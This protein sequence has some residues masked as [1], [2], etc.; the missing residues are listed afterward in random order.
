MEVLSEAALHSDRR[1]AVI[2]IMESSVISW[3]KQ[4]KVNDVNIKIVKALLLVI[5]IGSNAL[6]S[7][8]KYT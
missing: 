7:E 6:R 8:F 3:M 2:H 1:G 4:V 5:I